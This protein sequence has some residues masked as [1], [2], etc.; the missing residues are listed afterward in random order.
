M[1]GQLHPQTPT[2]SLYCQFQSGGPAPSHR[3]KGSAMAH[4]VVQFLRIPAVCKQF[5]YLVLT[6]SMNLILKSIIKFMLHSWYMCTITRPQS[7][8]PSYSWQGP[9]NYRMAIE[10]FCKYFRNVCSIYHSDCSCH[11]KPKGIL[12]TNHLIIHQAM[13]LTTAFQQIYFV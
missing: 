13:R 6:Y 3:E 4:I 10:T 7:L 8:W 5:T 2:Y 11:M 9:T 12:I 1:H